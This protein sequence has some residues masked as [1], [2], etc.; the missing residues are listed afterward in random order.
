MQKVQEL[1]NVESEL[2]VCNGTW[3]LPG[4]CIYIQRLH[5]GGIGIWKETYVDDQVVTLHLGLAEWKYK[6]SMS[7]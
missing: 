6:Y 5:K 1:E 2:I 4:L 7:W 3:E